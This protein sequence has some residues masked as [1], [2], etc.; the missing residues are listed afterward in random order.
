LKENFIK[1]LVEM[2]YEKNQ[3]VDLIEN[4]GIPEMNHNI[5]I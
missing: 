1:E 2:G 3:V 5:V 4:K